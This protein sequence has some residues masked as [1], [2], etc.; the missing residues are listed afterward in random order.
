MRKLPISHLTLFLILLIVYILMNQTGILAIPLIQRLHESFLYLSINKSTQKIT[1]HLSYNIVVNPVFDLKND[2]WT[3]TFPPEVLLHYYV[4]FQ[5]FSNKLQKVNL[6]LDTL[7]FPPSA[8]DEILGQILV[9]AST[10]N[11]RHNSIIIL[12]ISYRDFG[13]NKIFS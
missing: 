7:L 2:T 6:Y 9:F 10:E 8:L 13:W 1:L 5:H 3:K 12:I 4:A 11:Q